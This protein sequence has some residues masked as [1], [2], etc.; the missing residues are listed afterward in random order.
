MIVWLSDLEMYDCYRLFHVE[1]KIHV[2][3]KEMNY[4]PVSKHD[5]NTN[6]NIFFH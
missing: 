4:S 2:Y 6:E 1:L 5:Y 3:D